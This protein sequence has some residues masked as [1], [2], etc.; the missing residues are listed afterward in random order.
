MYV[1]FVLA[2]FLFLVEVARGKKK[3]IGY[4]DRK[5]AGV[6]KGKEKVFCFSSVDGKEVVE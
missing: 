4:E 6:W 5:G 1:S 3:R 2:C